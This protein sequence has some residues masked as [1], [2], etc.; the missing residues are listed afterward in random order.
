MATRGA[1][2]PKTGG[3]PR[4]FHHSMEFHGSAMSNT[5]A[6][7]G[8]SRACGVERL[9]NWRVAEAAASRCF[10]HEQIAGFHFDARGCAEMFD[11]P[12]RPHHPI[13]SG[14]PVLAAR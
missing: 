10:D 11:F 4:P 13:A 6:A 12:V 7:K 5:L 8:N 9:W 3:R 1:S 2:N 14:Q